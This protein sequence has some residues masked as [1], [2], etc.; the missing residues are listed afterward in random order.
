MYL[1]Y[2]TLMT[3]SP[4]QIRE[5]FPNGAN[6]AGKDITRWEPADSKPDRTLARLLRDKRARTEKP[7]LLHRDSSHGYT[8]I[9]ALSLSGEPEAVDEATQRRFSKEAKERFQSEKPLSER[10]RDLEEK[11]R[12]DQLASIEKRVR[13]VERSFQ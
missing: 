3:L 4:D 13:G 10:V 5:L 12:A 6:A 1:T 7:R 2:E 9:P 8:D 11:A